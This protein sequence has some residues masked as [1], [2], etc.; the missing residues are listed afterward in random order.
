MYDKE[1]KTYCIKMV[2]NIQYGGNSSK[3]RHK[4]KMVS[5]NQNGVV[6]WHLSFKLLPIIYITSTSQPLLRYLNISVFKTFDLDTVLRINSSSLH[7]S[8]RFVVRLYHA[9]Y[10]IKIKLIY[11]L[12]KD[13][14]QTLISISF[15]IPAQKSRF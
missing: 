13:R 10:W 11:R 12:T 8:C 6:G 2:S 7:L 1:Q 5:Q 3:W 15:S 4:L 9:G 14:D